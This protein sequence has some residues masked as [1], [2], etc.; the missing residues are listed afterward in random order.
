M[1]ISRARSPLY[2]SSLR[3]LSFPVFIHRICATV[4]IGTVPASPFPQRRTNFNFTLPSVYPLLLAAVLRPRLFANRLE[5]QIYTPLLDPPRK[6]SRGVAREPPKSN[7]PAP[8]AQPR[9]RVYGSTRVYVHGLTALPP[10]ALCRPL[11]L[12]RSL[13][14]RPARPP[15]RA[16]RV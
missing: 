11:D 4:V 16:A 10:F 12:L 15:R 7:F 1:Q 3:S 13:C 9:L 5:F 8:S 2:Y 14:L 6:L